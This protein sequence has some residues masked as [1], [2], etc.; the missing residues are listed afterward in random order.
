MLPLREI[1]GHEMIDV[2]HGRV[3]PVTVHAAVALFQ[4][5]GVPGDLV[6]D[7]P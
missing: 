7:E 4:T 5:A 3:L 6:M 1:R 2:H